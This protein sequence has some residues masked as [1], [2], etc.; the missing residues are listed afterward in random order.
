MTAAI[1]DRRRF[2]RRR[3]ETR[4]LEIILG[5]CDD[6]FWRIESAEADEIA[7]CGRCLPC[8]VQARLGP[9]LTDG[10]LDDLES[11]HDRRKI[12]E[13]RREQSAVRQERRRSRG[14]RR[15]RR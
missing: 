12:R 11:H 13:R 2:P 3:V 4:L 14:E 8:R 6:R 7:L 5:Q 9:A 15:V 10:I 1:T